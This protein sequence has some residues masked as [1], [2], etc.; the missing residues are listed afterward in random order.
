[1]LELTALHETAYLDLC[2]RFALAE[3]A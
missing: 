3:A 2:R 1:L